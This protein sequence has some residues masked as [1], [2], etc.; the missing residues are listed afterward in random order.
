MLEGY[1]YPKIWSFSNLQMWNNCPLCW[2]LKYL[3][4]K[5]SKDGNA[6]SQY[7][8]F[9]HGL[10]EQYEKGE[11]PLIALAE[12][13]DDGFD[14][15]VTKPW[16]MFPIGLGERYYQDGKQYLENFTGFGDQYEIIGVE[17]EFV[18]EIAGY[19]LIGYVDLILRDKN[20]GEITIVDHK[21]KSVKRL[22]QDWDELVLQLYIY[23]HYVHEKYGEWPKFLVFNCF[24]ESQMVGE[25][26]NPEEYE[27]MV[28]WV[29]TTITEILNATEF[30]DKIAKDANERIAKGKRPLKDN[31]YFCK[32]L[33][34]CWDACPIWQTEDLR[35]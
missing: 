21:S 35:M 13:Y 28:K 31:T 17:D 32:T 3:D 12:E 7:G 26:F 1:K 33:C 9:V 6:F 2:K 25:E 23:A 22:Q 10:L 34:D 5:A 30:P 19:K 18:T 27:R 24:R 15:N 16:P 29:E 8:S 20:T 14:D 11:L 4:Q